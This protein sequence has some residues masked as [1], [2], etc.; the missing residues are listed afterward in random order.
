M[1]EVNARKKRAIT[2]FVALYV[3]FAAVLAYLFFLS[4]SAKITEDPATIGKMVY[5]END[6]TQV[7][8]NLQVY[9]IHEQEKKVLF[10]TKK[11]Y[12]GEKKEIDLTQI[13]GMDEVELFVTAD[14]H[15][16]YSKKIPLIMQKLSMS[17]TV[18]T[19]ADI[20]ENAQF[21]TILEI[22]NTGNVATE[23]KVT[24]QHDLQYFTEDKEQKFAKINPE[25][26]NS[27]RYSLKPLK[28][29]ETVML[30]KVEFQK[31]TEEI[32]KMIEVK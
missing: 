6:S 12:K 2:V 14:F 19:P 28:K 31:S 9:Y 23:V 25:T 7:M 3:V 15:Q 17:Y 29:G 24:Q 18:K 22:C 21:E 5:I 27:F 1:F 4:P 10:E 32:K 16:T 13:T 8:K 11:L 20:F 30:F 26:C